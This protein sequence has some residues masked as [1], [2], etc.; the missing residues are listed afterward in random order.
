LHYLP[1]ISKELQYLFT[2]EKIYYTWTHFLWRF[3]PISGHG[4]PL[5][6][7]AFTLTGHT[8]VGRTPLDEWSTWHWD[9]SQHITLTTDRHPWPG[10]IRTHNPSKRAFAHPILRLRSHWDRL[11]DTV[12]PLRV[13]CV[14]LT[15]IVPVLS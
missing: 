10:R 5:R 14:P 11:M 15:L 12:I 13:Y 8:T 9:F 6:G 1:Y 3:D 2:W 7:F 4:F